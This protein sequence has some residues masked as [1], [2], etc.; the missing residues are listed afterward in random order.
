[1]MVLI[2]GLKI[3]PN[4]A[5]PCRTRARI[6]SVKPVI[7]APRGRFYDQ[8]ELSHAGWNETIQRASK[9]MSQNLGFLWVGDMHKPKMSKISLEK[10]FSASHGIFSWLFLNK[11]LL[12]KIPNSLGTSS[13]TQAVPWRLCR[14]TAQW[15]CTVLSR[16]RHKNY[17]ACPKEP[18]AGLTSL[19]DMSSGL[20]REDRSLPFPLVSL[21]WSPLWVARF[22]TTY[23]LIPCFIYCSWQQ[24][25]GMEVNSATWWKKY[26]KMWT[27]L[28]YCMWRILLVWLIY[29]LAG[30]SNE[31]LVLAAKCI[32][33]GQWATKDPELPVHQAGLCRK[34]EVTQSDSVLGGGFVFKSREI[35]EVSGLVANTQMSR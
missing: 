2:T 8:L 35:S 5:I 27:H 18:R 15:L 14:F 6:I 13:G 32:P 23:K 28:F 11:A 31:T 19:A 3:T 4:T 33:G 16:L 22:R 17:S 24:T 30:A 9:S 1:M 21:P 7:I 20:L 12:S 25:R 26:H 29:F 34:I 10:I